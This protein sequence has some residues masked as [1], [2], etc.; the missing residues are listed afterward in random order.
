MLQHCLYLGFHQQLCNNF[1][2]EI[3]KLSMSVLKKKVNDASQIP[4]LASI[5][6]HSIL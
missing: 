3:K 4:S 5:F 6:G 2:P 1:S